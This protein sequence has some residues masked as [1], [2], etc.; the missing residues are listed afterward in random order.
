MLEEHLEPSRYRLHGRRVVEGQ[1][2]LQA[3]SDIFLGWSK[4]GTGRE[5]YWRQL[6]DWKGSADL[7]TIS[8]SQL[9]RYATMCGATMARAHAVTGDPVAIAAY[10]GKGDVFDKAMGEYAIRYAAQNAEDYAAFIAEITAGR[11]GAVELGD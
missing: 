11:L 8:K 10:L 7:E 5:Y 4:S 9:A 3:V 2:L 1:R 6:K